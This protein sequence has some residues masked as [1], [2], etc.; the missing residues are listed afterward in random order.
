MDTYWSGLSILEYVRKEKIVTFPQVLS[1]CPD[2]S[3]DEVEANIGT[4]KNAGL[5]MDKTT[6]VRDRTLRLIKLAR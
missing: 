6:G 5:I 1:A 3:P 2:I 4:L